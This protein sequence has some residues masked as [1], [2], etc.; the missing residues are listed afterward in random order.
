MENLTLGHL[1]GDLMEE[2]MDEDGDHITCDFQAVF[3]K[4]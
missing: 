1:C 4:K 3:K 2:V